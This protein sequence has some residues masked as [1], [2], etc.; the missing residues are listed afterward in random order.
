MMK[1]I[2]RRHETSTYE[3]RDAMI[4]KRAR[5]HL[6]RLRKRERQRLHGREP[7]RPRGR[8][9]LSLRPHRLRWIAAFSISL[10]AGILLARPL[11]PLILSWASAE[12]GGLESIAI[13]GNSQLSFN[14]VAIATGVARGQQ[15]AEIDLDQVETRLREQPWIKNAHVLRLPPAT[16]VVRVDE[17]EPRALLVDAPGRTPPGR[18]RLVDEEGVVFAIASGREDLPQFVGGENLETGRGHVLL[19]DGLS[20][21]RLLKSA[22]IETVVSPGEAL[23]VHL[24]NDGSSEG[25]IVRGRIEVILGQ[26]QHEARIRRLVEL[27]GNQEVRELLSQQDLRVDLRFTDQAVL[28]RIGPDEQT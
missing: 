1:N 21:L 27:L 7:G 14:D 9:A 13:Q 17:R 4:S 26:G 2:F 18:V 20:L 25:W 6:A 19:A 5:Q 28:E 11:E 3:R 10:A 8:E 15:L 22:E 23:T 16:L 12:L 24:P